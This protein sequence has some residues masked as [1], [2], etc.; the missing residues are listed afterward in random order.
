MSVVCIECLDRKC[1]LEATGKFAGAEWINRG[2]DAAAHCATEKTV[3]LAWEGQRAEVVTG[4]DQDVGTE[5]HRVPVGSEQAGAR[6]V[7]L[8]PAY[9]SGPKLRHGRR[10]HRINPR[11]KA[12]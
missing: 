6:W 4:A 3:T 10:F 7:F 1:F 9:K 12:D 2:F 11:I 5:T 8:S